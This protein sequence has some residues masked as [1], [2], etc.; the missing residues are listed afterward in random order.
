MHHKVE[1]HSDVERG[2]S[3][4]AQTHSLSDANAAGTLL[5]VRS[6]LRC[7]LDKPL[8]HLLQGLLQVQGGLSHPD[9]VTA[10]VGLGWPLWTNKSMSR[11]TRE[12]E[13]GLGTQSE[14]LC[15]AFSKGETLLVCF[16]THY[17]WYFKICWKPGGAGSVQIMQNDTKL[18]QHLKPL[19]DGDIMCP[20]VFSVAGTLLITVWFLRFLDDRW[21]PQECSLAVSPGRPLFCKTQSEKLDEGKRDG[22]WKAVIR[23]AQ[24]NQ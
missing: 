3:T 24:G 17:L 7:S 19:R 12:C 22:L 1:E 14:S 18:Q 9:A 2:D 13:T 10:V 4:H 11:E 20:G 8:L 6:T 21:N 16:L 23:S 5:A 15:S